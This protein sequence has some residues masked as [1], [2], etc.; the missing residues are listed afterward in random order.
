M[1]TGFIYVMWNIFWLQLAAFLSCF[2]LL[3]YANAAIRGQRRE[4]A[5]M[6]MLAALALAVILVVGLAARHMQVRNWDD[7]EFKEMFVAIGLATAA[8]DTSRRIWQSKLTRPSKNL[9]PRATRTSSA[10]ARAAA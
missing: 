5:F 2:I 3:A 4:E 6:F 8:L 9:S 10:S 1:T 7:T